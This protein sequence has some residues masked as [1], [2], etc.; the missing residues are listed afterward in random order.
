MA[1]RFSALISDC[2]RHSRHT[3]WDQLR[4]LDYEEA[5]TDLRAWLLERAP[6]PEHSRPLGI[7]FAERNVALRLTRLDVV[8]RAYGP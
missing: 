3:A 2:E 1:L 5:A 8:H 4:G 6:I 7:P